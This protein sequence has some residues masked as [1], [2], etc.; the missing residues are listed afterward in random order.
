M[1]GLHV[2]TLAGTETIGL[3]ASFDCLEFHFPDGVKEAKRCHA[4]VMTTML[5]TG[6]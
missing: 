1:P 2:R 5:K 3:K 6:E 4:Y